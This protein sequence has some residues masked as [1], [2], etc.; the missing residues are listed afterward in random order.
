MKIRAR[1][2][3]NDLIQTSGTV[4][5]VTEEMDSGM[6]GSF[7][8]LEAKYGWGRIPT[9]AVGLTSPALTRSVQALGKVCLSLHCVSP[10]FL[11]PVSWTLPSTQ[12][13]WTCRRS[14][15]FGSGGWGIHYPILPSR[16]GTPA[17]DHLGGGCPALIWW[18]HFP[19]TSWGAC[20]LLAL[21]VVFPLVP[22]L[23]VQIQ[24]PVWCVIISFLDGFTAGFFSVCALLGTVQTSPLLFRKS[25]VH[26]WLRTSPWGSSPSC[27]LYRWPHWP[28]PGRCSC[29]YLPCFEAF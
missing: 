20:A 19:R 15:G 17:T 11:H 1:S 6:W 10:S 28:I 25:L 5:A 9:Q 3:D 13:Q 7:F 29:T 8:N 16:N 18:A 26:K 2:L 4:G 22:T 14:R 21:C 12:T 23:V 24:L 27:G